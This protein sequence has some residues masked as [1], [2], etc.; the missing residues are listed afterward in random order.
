MNLAPQANVGDGWLDLVL[1]Q[2]AERKQFAKFLENI[3]RGQENQNQLNT[4]RVKELEV[5][6][7]SPHYHVDD[8][9]QEDTIPV[10]IKIKV[11]P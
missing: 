6:W 8:Q 1:V 2:K 3:L 4:R 10:K 11:I 9:A 5:E 7:H